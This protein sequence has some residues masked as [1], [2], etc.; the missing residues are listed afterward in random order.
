VREEDAQWLGDPDQSR[1]LELVTE[2]ARGRCRGSER[3]RSSIWVSRSRRDPATASH[4]LVDPWMAPRA[5]CAAGNTRSRS[6][7]SRASGQSWACSAVR[8]SRSTPRS[9]PGCRRVALC[10]SH[11]P[12]GDRTALRHGIRGSSPAPARAGPAGGA[13]AHQFVR[14]RP[15]DDEA[16][17]RVAA[18]IGAR[19]GLVRVDSALKYVLV[20]R[21]E[22]DAYLRLNP[23]PG[24]VDHAWDHA[25]G[26]LIAS[27]AE[28]CVTD[29]R[30]RPLEFSRGRCLAGA[31]GI[32][33]ARPELC[34]RLLEALARLGIG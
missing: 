14:A 4:W 11:R 31:G 5:T 1:E 22:A 17:A 20:A 7:W 21:G 2:V 15:P 27:E 3:V 16:L 13:R 30:G 34:G 25:A 33:A 24:S 19:P 8:R 6:R 32:V 23:R 12:R 26:S 9:T 29:L 28:A 10:G 18:E